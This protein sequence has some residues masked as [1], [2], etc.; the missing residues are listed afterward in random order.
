MPTGLIN[1]AA[2]IAP[3]FLTD[4]VRQTLTGL[5][6][7]GDTCTSSLLLLRIVRGIH[8][9][10]PTSARSP[11]FQYEDSSTWSKCCYKHDFGL[12]CRSETA[13]IV[14][15]EE[16]AG[17]VCIILSETKV[18]I[19]LLLLIS[20]TTCIKTVDLIQPLRSTPAT[21]TPWLRFI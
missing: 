1:R 11:Q 3:T 18:Y 12:P 4:V 2:P 5:L 7:T 6:R 9:I 14:K 19:T 21:V 17:T 10:Q 8:V 13:P 20:S 16:L 15:P